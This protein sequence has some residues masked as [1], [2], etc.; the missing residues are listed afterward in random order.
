MLLITNNI[1][2]PFTKDFL[3]C[4]RCAFFAKRCVIAISQSFTK[5]HKE[6]TKIL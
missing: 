6:A 2:F 5:F 4:K 1:N 3:S